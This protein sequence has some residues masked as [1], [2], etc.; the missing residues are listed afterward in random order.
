MA[1][2]NHA[3][4][5]TDRALRT[6]IGRVSVRVY[7]VFGRM[8]VVYRWGTGGDL[9]GQEDDDSRVSVRYTLAPTFPGPRLSAK[10]P[11]RARRGVRWH[12]CINDAWGVKPKARPAGQTDDSCCTGDREDRRRLTRRIGAAAALE[13]T[14]M[15]SALREAVPNE[16]QAGSAGAPARVLRAM[17]A[18]PH[19]CRRSRRCTHAQHGA[20]ARDAK[21]ERNADGERSEPEHERGA[22]RARG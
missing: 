8:S 4:I 17:R 7:A 10:V 15:R 20:A 6:C 1:A 18:A 14:A 16:V 13:R 3:G 12:T 2:A 22:K 11:E 5:P 9:R 21:A 19:R